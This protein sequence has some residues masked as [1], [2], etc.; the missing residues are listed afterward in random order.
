M[1]KII[2][3]LIIIL[4]IS[5]SSFI[6]I[7]NLKKEELKVTVISINDE[8]ILIQDK[9][10]IIYE[11]DNTLDIELGDKIKIYYKDEL[12][13]KNIIKY[14]LL[15][16]SNLDSWND[17]GL[18]SEYYEQAYQKLNELTLDEKIAQL[19][20][21]R[22]PDNAI[23]EL[24]QY[25]FGGFIFFKK[26]FDNKTKEEVI[27]MI[28]ELQKVSKIPLITA[29]DEEGG[30]VVRISSNDKLYFEKFKSPRE[31]YLEGGFDKI[32]ED[33]ILKSNLLNELGIN[34][35]LAPVVDVSTNPDD[36]MYN[37]TIGEDVDITSKYAKTVIKAS[38]GTNVSYALKHFPGYGSNL[39]THNGISI[40]ERS[41]EEL[42][43]NSL[44]PF[45]EGIKTQA[46]VVLVS[47]NIIQS[48]D[49]D[50][51]A[52]LSYKVHNILRDELNFTGI[53]VT[54]DLVMKALDQYPKKN[55]M[56]LLAGNDLLITTDY[57]ESIEDIKNGIKDG[58]ISEE[59]I[60][61][62]AFRVIS[63]KYY[64]GLMK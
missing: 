31:L 56:A 38:K 21:V 53:I 64:K 22:Y 10:N 35:N 44:P 45:E 46:E 58:L 59:L 43:N 1:K 34:L 30:K 32:K 27:N 57:K 29:V 37:R 63:W 55:V 4:V 48:I 51:L 60:N 39:D 47:H 12:N 6:V 49:N 20:I 17:N 8:R 3:S 54:D 36:Y 23:E 5:V 2:F 9:N 62:L 50:N 52:T 18:F 11:L 19:L 42:L 16:E 14:E 28:D 15:K 41:Y 7:N 33:T 13:T 40:D 24:K 61:K 25:Q 26:D